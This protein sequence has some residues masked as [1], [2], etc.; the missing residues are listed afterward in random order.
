MLAT[1]QHDHLAVA[2]GFALLLLL[3]VHMCLC[4]CVFIY[5]CNVCSF[6]CMTDKYVCV[7]T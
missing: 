5:M 2:E 7:C 6:V 1:G 4:V 3:C